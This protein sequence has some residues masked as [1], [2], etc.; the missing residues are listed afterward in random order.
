MK[1]KLLYTALICISAIFSRATDTPLQACAK[2]KDVNEQLLCI[3]ELIRNSLNSDPK[4]AVVYASS[5]LEVAQEH[6]LMEDVGRGWNFLGMVY[7][8]MGSTDKAVENY[9]KAL[10]IFEQIG[11]QQMQG[12]VLNNIGAAH[13]YRNDFENTTK[14]YRQSLE[15]FQR[16]RDIE[17][18]ASVSYNLANIMLDQDHVDEAKKWYFYADSIYAVSQEYNVLRGYVAGALSNCYIAEGDENK[19]LIQC[20]KAL[21]LVDSLSDYLYHS[22]VYGNMCKCFMQMQNLDSAEVYCSKSIHIAQF[23]NAAKELKESHKN[24][25]ELQEKRGNLVVALK[26][27]KLYLAYS[28]SLFN[29]EK[30]RNLTNALTQ[31]E[32][33][34]KEKEL[35][36]KNVELLRSEAKNKNTLIW[37]ALIGSILALVLALAVFIYK[38]NKV[39]ASKNQIIEDALSQKEILLREIHHR[40]KNNL[41]I[42]SSLLNIQSRYIENDSALEAIRESRNRVRA[43]ALIHQDLYT[44]DSATDVESSSYI[45]KLAHGLI[46]TYHVTSEHI[47]LHIETEKMYLDVDTLIPLGLII[48]ELITNSL[49]HAF[50]NRECGALWVNL[51]KEYGGVR[52]KIADNGEGF[53]H[54]KNYD[55]FG[56]RMIHVFAEKLKANYSFNTEKGTT[57]DMFIPISSKV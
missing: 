43:M 23:V 33:E 12:I 56:L 45:N 11:H 55:S 37:L 1:L 31:Y 6:N 15:I 28:D 4:Q 22:T 35:V 21:S 3:Q 41:Q 53:D 14:Y 52:L 24:M 34:K 36:L 42:V 48:N 7:Y 16:I 44:H 17:W 32:S 25:A 50:K 5:Y 18:I 57:F 51:V 39:L 30:D 10:P 47:E 40:V 19:A 8:T 38:N 27:Y 20:K 46:E 49:K 13:L 9:L 54:T 26:N 2:L 29:E